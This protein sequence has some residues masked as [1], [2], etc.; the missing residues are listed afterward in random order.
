MTEE[1][2]YRI[3]VLTRRIESSVREFLDVSS[4]TGHLEVYRRDLNDLMGKFIEANE[5]ARTNEMGDGK[6]E[7]LTNEEDA[8]MY[9]CSFPEDFELE[10][11]KANKEGEE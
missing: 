2:N 6:A 7:V 5:L 1:E 10:E 9:T 11:R 3:R 8:V 4:S